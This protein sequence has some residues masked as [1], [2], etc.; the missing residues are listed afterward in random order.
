MNHLSLAVSVVFLSFLVG[1]QATNKSL[2]NQQ[3]FQLSPGLD[4]KINVP[5]NYSIAPDFL[6]FEN[7]DLISK[8]MVEEITSPLSVVTAQ[9]NE[10][11]FNKVQLEFINSENITI[12]SRQATFITLKQAIN[13][14]YFEKLWL[15]TGDELSSVKIAA[16]YPESKRENTGQELK[17]SLLST[18]LKI[19]MQK[20]IFTGL[21]FTFN[22]NNYYQIAM[23]ASNSIVLKAT[24]DNASIVFSHGKVH[25]KDE[26]KESLSQFF[27]DSAKSLENIEVLSRD[28][29]KV[30]GLPAQRVIAYG[31]KEG[32]DI[33]FS[34]TLV[35]SGDKFTLIHAMSPKDKKITASDEL[36]KLLKTFSFKAI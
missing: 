3:R 30:S 24:E 25:A 34:Q 12:D 10:Q 20:R 22:T 4:I 36:D 21:P 28:T 33:W 5:V 15:L 27:I 2:M 19:D 13:G 14:V 31:Q 26:N 1:C 16:S 18:A 17:R 35:I 11:A 29:I 8:I 23:R 7:N 6:G 32:E 9:L